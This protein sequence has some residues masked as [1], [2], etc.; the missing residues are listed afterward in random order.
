MIA[1][2]GEPLLPVLTSTAVENGGEGRSKMVVLG[3]ID[4]P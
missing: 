3:G 2:K 4:L 1:S